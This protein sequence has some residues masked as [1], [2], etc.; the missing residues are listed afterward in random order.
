VFAKRAAAAGYRVVAVD[1][2]TERLP[3]DLPR[4]IEFVHADVREFPIQGYD[5]ITV[6]GLLYHLRLAQQLELLVECRGGP[7][8]VDTQVH[9]PE[10]VT[11]AAGPWARHIV[12]EGDYEGVYFPEGDNPMASVGNAESFWHTHESL[13]RLYENS[14]FE[15]VQ[16][17]EPYYVSKYGARQFY[18]C[19]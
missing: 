6:L 13:L 11:S 8:V 1:A 5:V 9:V 10:A 2:R 7:V 15:S 12:H 16:V 4:E 14:G 19:R 17:V 18:V 3:S